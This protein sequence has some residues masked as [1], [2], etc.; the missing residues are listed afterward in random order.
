VFA[1]AFALSVIFLAQGR[2]VAS[3]WSLAVALF[4]FALQAVGHKREIVPPEPF[5]GPVN[6]VQ[7][8]VAEQYFKFWRFLVSGDFVRAFRE[9]A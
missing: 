6:F 8:I 7:R 2:L 1:L 3:G 5:T 4:S 9:E